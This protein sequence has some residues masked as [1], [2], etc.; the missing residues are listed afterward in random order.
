MT[1]IEFNSH[2]VSLEKHLKSYAYRLTTN[3]DES[4]DLYQDTMLKALTYKNKFT[5]TNLKAWLLT[6][7][8]NIF[9]NGYRRKVIK[10]E[11]MAQETKLN[12]NLS[13]ISYD[14]PTS[15]Q[16]YK[17]IMHELEKLEVQ[18]KEPFRMFLAGFKYRE[19]AEKMSLPIGTI[20]SRIFQ[21]RKELMVNLR[22]F[23]SYN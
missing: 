20:K 16:N 7:M 1:T 4:L 13:N 11:W 15:I 17:D 19:I 18:I 23:S 8:K 12:R 22:E 6:I 10:R 5:H 9:I 21:G 14:N 2:I 3:H